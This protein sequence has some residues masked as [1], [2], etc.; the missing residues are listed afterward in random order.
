MPKMI[1]QNMLKITIEHNVFLHTNFISTVRL[2]KLIDSRNI[3]S[4]I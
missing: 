2:T 4:T 3:I 1:C